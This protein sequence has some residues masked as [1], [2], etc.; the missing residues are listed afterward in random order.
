MGGYSF[1]PETNMAER[2]KELDSS[3]INL[4]LDNQLVAVYNLTY[5]PGTYRPSNTNPFNNFNWLIIVTMLII[6][7]LVLSFLVYKRK[8]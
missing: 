4:Y 2:L 3:K 1:Y 8:K 7:V 5:H 6:I